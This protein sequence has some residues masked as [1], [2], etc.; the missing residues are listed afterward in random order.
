MLFRLFVVFTLMMTFSLAACG[1]DKDSGIDTK[2][3][4]ISVADH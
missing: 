3:A 4:T 1:E 2:A